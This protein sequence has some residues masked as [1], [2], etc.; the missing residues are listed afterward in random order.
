[1]ALRLWRALPG[2]KVADAGL[3]W[4]S[5]PTAGFGPEVP[6]ATSRIYGLQRRRRSHVGIGGRCAGPR[7]RRNRDGGPTPG[8]VEVL[9]LGRFMIES[10]WPSA[11]QPSPPR[12]GRVLNL[13]TT[14][15]DVILRARDEGQADRKR[16]WVPDSRT[17]AIRPAAS[18]LT[19]TVESQTAVN[20]IN[21]IIP[22]YSVKT[23]VSAEFRAINISLIELNATSQRTDW[24]AGT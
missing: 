10:G 11:R 17:V 6:D 19:V 3:T 5:S 12:S 14:R 8:H 22:I 9:E 15:G 7:P 20:V 13:D 18:D 1:M 4:R 16:I 2:Q 24:R 23:L 21:V